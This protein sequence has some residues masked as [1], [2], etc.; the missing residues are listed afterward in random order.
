MTKSGCLRRILDW[1]A[2]R[3]ASSARA[4]ENSV[5]PTANRVEGPCRWRS[6]GHIMG[7]TLWEIGTDLPRR[8]DLERMATSLLGVE[9]ILDGVD[10]LR[11]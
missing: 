5:D 2:C 1:G 6:R 11:P 4:D 3:T 10:R 7:F 9:L 8:G